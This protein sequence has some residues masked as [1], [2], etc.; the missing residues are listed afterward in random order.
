MDSNRTR[1]GSDGTCTDTDDAGMSTGI[2]GTGT[3]GTDSTDTYI[4]TSHFHW[5]ILRLSQQS[6]FTLL[7]SDRTI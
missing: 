6:E 5:W 2:T 3:E 1:S 4:D 7:V